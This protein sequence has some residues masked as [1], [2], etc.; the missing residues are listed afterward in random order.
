MKH[1]FIVAIAFSLLSVMAQTDRGIIA[2][3]AVDPS[4]ASIPDAKV[5]ATQ[6]GTNA[7]FESVTT[8][9]GD[10]T[11]PSLP[12][13]QYRVR[14]ERQ[15]FKSFVANEVILTAGNTVTVRAV[16]QVGAVAETIEVTSNASQ[17]QTENAKTQTAVSHKLVD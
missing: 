10:F 1:K 4:G 9:S 2:G 13:G 12:V 3:S 11:I 5:T 7:T 6:I 14:V 17:V 16:L 15:G 8:S